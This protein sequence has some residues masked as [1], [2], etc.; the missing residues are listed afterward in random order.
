MVNQKAK[1]FDRPLLLNRKRPVCHRA[2]GS[3]GG[4]PLPHLWPSPNLWGGII[5]RLSPLFPFHLTDLKKG[6]VILKD[7]CLA[8]EPEWEKKQSGLGISLPCP[9]AEMLDNPAVI[10][11]P[12]AENPK[13]ALFR[14][15]KFKAFDRLRFGRKFFVPSGEIYGEAVSMLVQTNR[16]AIGSQRVNRHRSWSL[17]EAHFGIALEFLSD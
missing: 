3:Q 1:H 8:A 2:F 5:V 13:P 17:I 15:P 7:A 11:S 9:V 6:Q 10:K 14:K 12:P 4:I 16:E